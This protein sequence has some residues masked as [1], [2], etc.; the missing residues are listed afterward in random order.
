M[1]KSKLKHRWIGPAVNLNERVLEL[2]QKLGLHPLVCQILSNRGFKSAESVE[3]FLDP[4]L[5]DLLDPYL[6]KGMDAAV[7]RVVRALQSKEKIVIYGDYDVDGITSI[8]L[9]VRYLRQLNG[10][11]G[12]FIPHRMVEGYG[13]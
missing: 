2:E 3:K 5:H 1:R 13:L 7:D 8:S 12:Y 6:M 4:S 11:V 9:M 10:D